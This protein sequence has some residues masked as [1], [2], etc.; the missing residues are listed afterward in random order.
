M[1]IYAQITDG[2]IIRTTGGFTGPGYGE[3]GEWHD[4]S[5]PDIRDSYLAEHGWHVVTEVDRP[6]DTDTHTH[7]LTYEIVAGQ[8][9]QVWTARERT[10]EEIAARAERDARLDDH[11]AR[12]AAL[13]AL[14]MAGAIPD[15]PADP[16]VPTWADLTPA[17]WWYDGTLLRDGGKVWRNVSG[18]VL[19]TPPTGFPGGPGRWTHL[20]VEVTTGSDPEPDPTHPEDYVGPWS[21]T[22]TYEVGDVVD[23]DGRYYR[24]KVAHGPEY[25]GTWGPPN[26]SVWDD[27]GSAA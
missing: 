1:V 7:V 4:F 23:R 10:P 6:A 25:A 26:A 16:D 19:T 15:D 17:G 8:P 9:T 20:F 12:I 5:D 11:E 3:D 21:E 13:E 18:T 22:A 2:T 14:I 27:I 24:C